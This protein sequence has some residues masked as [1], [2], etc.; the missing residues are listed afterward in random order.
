MTP[1]LALSLPRRTIDLLEAGGVG[2]VEYL[3]SMPK[4][5]LLAVPGLDFRSYRTVMSKLEIYL[6]LKEAR[7][8]SDRQFHGA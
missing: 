6:T 5:D 8:R 3:L 1:L 4:R 2:S 7:E